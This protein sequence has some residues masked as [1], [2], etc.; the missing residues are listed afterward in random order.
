MAPKVKIE[1]TLPS[2]ER[3]TITLEGKEVSKTRVL[4]IME[5]LSIMSGGGVS[6]EAADEESVSMKERVWRIILERFGDGAWFTLRELHSILAEEE[7]EMKITTLASYLAKFVSEGRLMKKGQKP[8]TLYRVR[9][10]AAR[11]KG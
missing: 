10:A 2:G 9:M 3:I 11:A 7:P 4:Q 5:M 8:S 1:E 6:E